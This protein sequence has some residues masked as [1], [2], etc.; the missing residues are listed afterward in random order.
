MTRAAR[1]AGIAIAAVAPLVLATCRDGEPTGFGRIARASVNL[2]SLASAA[3]PGQPNVPLDS[4]RVALTRVGDLAPA[5]DTVL[6][7]RGDTIA[8]DSLVLRLQVQLR[9]DPENFSIAITTYGAGLTWYQASGTAVLSAT[10]PATPVLTAVYVG[11]GA[12]AARVSVGPR[13]TVMLGGHTIGLR[14]TVYDSS[15]APIANVP[16]GYRLSDTT[17]GAVA[18]PTYLTGTFTAAG[19]VRDSVWLIAETPTHLRDST[20]IH[21]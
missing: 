11:P 12:N 19:A 7:A 6:R 16:V 15:N 17:R 9:T 8:G 18:L 14:A 13:D 4:I 5:L 1:F 2:A 21:I 3:T 20:R 10:K